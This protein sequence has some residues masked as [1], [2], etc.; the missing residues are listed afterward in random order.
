MKKSNP[1]KLAQTG[2][3]M[4]EVLATKVSEPWPGVKYSPTHSCEIF[5]MY[6]QVFSFYCQVCYDVLKKPNLEIIFIR[7]LDMDFNSPV[8]LVLQETTTPLTLI[9]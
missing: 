5:P 6:S 9:Q 8:S 4:H 3:Y 7:C 2:S 1:F